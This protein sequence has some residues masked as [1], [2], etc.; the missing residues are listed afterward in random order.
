MIKLK[1]P[2]NFPIIDMSP[3]KIDNRLRELFDLWR[4]MQQLKCARLIGTVNEI[5]HHQNLSD[6]TH[7]S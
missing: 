2:Q 7:T 5:E 3:K 6:S 4:I 1:Q